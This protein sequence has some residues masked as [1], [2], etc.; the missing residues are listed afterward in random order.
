MTSLTKAKAAMAKAYHQVPR[1][2]RWQHRAR[3]TKYTVVTLALHHETLEV[4][5]VYR[6]LKTEVA[7]VR[8]FEEFTDGRFMRLLDR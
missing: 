1:A 5:V 6:D 8:P 4:L 7:W 2:S 3:L